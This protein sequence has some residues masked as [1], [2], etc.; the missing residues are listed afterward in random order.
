M[1]GQWRLAIVSVAQ[2]LAI[3]IQT[4]DGLQWFNL[5]WVAFTMVGNNTH[6]SET[7]FPIV[8]FPPPLVSW[9]VVLSSLTWLSRRSLLQLSVGCDS[10]EASECPWTALYC[11]RH[12]FSFKQNSTFLTCII[13]NL[14][15]F[16]L[17]WFFSGP[18]T[19]KQGLHTKPSILW[20]TERQE[21]EG[22]D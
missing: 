14:A 2:R 8:H 17:I 13:C 7:M 21:V 9:C 18:H 5:Q 20:T 15:S 19:A 16:D 10:M 6:S 22:R 12:A 4:M 1:D 11:I 3:W